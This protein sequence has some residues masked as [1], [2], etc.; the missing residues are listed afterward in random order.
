MNRAELEA[1]IWRHW[2]TRDA[3]AV[4]AVDTILAAADAYA[5]TE[6]GITAERRRELQAAVYAHRRRGAA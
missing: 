4:D 1:V 3:E 2:P 5:V 6:G